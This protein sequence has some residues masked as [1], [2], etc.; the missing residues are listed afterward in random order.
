ML[1][2]IIKKTKAKVLNFS[3]ATTGLAY[4]IESAIKRRFGDISKSKDA[5]IAVLVSPKVG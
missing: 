2:T 4:A 5:V 3:A 1:H